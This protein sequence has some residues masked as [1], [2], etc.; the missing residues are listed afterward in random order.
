MREHR[1][2]WLVL[3]VTVAAVGG[4]SACGGHSGGAHP[5]PSG[6][7]SVASAPPDH[8]TGRPDSTSAYDPPRFAAQ[9]IKHAHQAKIAPQLLMAI[10]YNESDKPHD[11]A[12]E[13]AWQR[14]KPDAAFGIAD[15]HRAAFDEVKR[16]R[17]FAGRR[18]EELPDDPD[19]AITAAAWYLHDLA[20][21]LPAHWSAKYSRNELLALGYN[22][23]PGTMRAFARGAK[24]GAIAQSYLDR[25]RQNWNAAG[26]ALGG[27]RRQSP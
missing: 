27:Q 22:A 17:N 5:R 12:F 24:P 11:P 4:A 7:S 18:W 3:L 2:R 25:L 15:M 21:R 1:G 16:G 9:V 19:L 10:L 6:T 8:A 13:R 23:G 14:I 20:A 26:G